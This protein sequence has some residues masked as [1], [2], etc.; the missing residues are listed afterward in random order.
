MHYLPYVAQ[1]AKLRTS[2]HGRSQNVHSST[3]RWVQIPRN[4][5]GP[6]PSDLQLS[7]AKAQE[8]IR[9][10]WL[11]YNSGSRYIYHEQEHL[12]AHERM[13][14]RACVCFAGSTSRKDV[15]SRCLG[16]PGVPWRAFAALSPCFGRLLCLTL[17]QA[18]SKSCSFLKGCTALERF[19]GPCTYVG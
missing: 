13:G 4:D 14:T 8:P 6:A 11:R 9:S 3:P 19:Y 12:L 16:M 2:M 5:A 10:H 17:L 18:R 15:A 7:L 1:R